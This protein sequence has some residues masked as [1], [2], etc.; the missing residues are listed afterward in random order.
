MLQKRIA[1]FVNNLDEEYQISI[2]KAAREAAK[3][4]GYQLIC[5][6][7]ETIFANKR[8]SF[9]FYSEPWLKVDGILFL[10]SVLGQELGKTEQDYISQ[11][12]KHIPCV[13]I[14]KDLYNFSSILIH[15]KEAFSSLI[16]H[17]VDT[18][19]YRNILYIGGP[20]KHHDNIIREQVLVELTDEYNN[21]DI[22]IV[23]T[24][25]HGAFH[26][27][28]SMVITQKYIQQK[29]SDPFDVIIAANDNMAIGA[30]KAI[31]TSEN[32]NWKK[33]AITG[34]DDIPLASLEYP[35][36]TTI[37]QPL[38]ALGKEAVFLLDSLI[39]H[40][41]PTTRVSARRYVACNLVI[42]ESCG[43][44]TQNQPPVITENIHNY[45]S[46][47]PNILRGNKTSLN[48]TDF[49]TFLYLSIKT[50][51]NMRNLSY[52][53]QRLI[54]VNTHEGMV[55]HLSDFL[56]NLSVSLC[57]LFIFPEPTHNPQEMAHLI[58]KRSNNHDEYY[59]MSSSLQSIREVLHE[60]KEQVLCVY[61]LKTGDKFV[62]I[63]VYNSFDYAQPH[64]CSCATFL[65]NN[66]HRLYE[67]ELEKK[68]TQILE[69][70]VQQ[71]TQELVKA[72]RELQ[73]ESQ[74]REAVELEVLRI[75]EM[76]RLRFSLDLHDDICQRLAGLSM[77]CKSMVSQIPS[78][79]EVIKMID[80][81][82]LL[83]RR[84]A[85]DAFPVELE[86]LGLEKALENLLS[87]MERHTSCAYTFHWDCPFES[88]TLSKAQE[89]NIY[90]IVQEAVNNSIKHGHATQL[91][92]HA[93]FDENKI[94]YISLSDNGHG[95]DLLNQFPANIN[96]GGVGLRSMQYRTHQL[97][98]TLRIQ[99][100]I[101]K[102]TTV[103]IAIPVE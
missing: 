63:L 26:E 68:R 70:Q 44:H 41:D 25:E 36:L 6:Q 2:F 56:S 84:Y 103:S 33:C 78:L 71:R 27:Y 54:T 15:S 50:E 3:T 28:S 80:E 89:I 92:V 30:I 96:V 87:T 75:S 69:E 102:G 7:S 1:L 43:C 14:G 95:N 51:Q 73:E 18:H 22:P 11:L 37:H 47:P 91:T 74:R 35:P 4:L 97:H 40:I 20:E 66:V 85:H 39:H 77:Y 100:S 60:E 5:I 57:F 83:T 90:R 13:S 21:K 42:R 86:N 79:H 65:S 94:F 61:P 49:S 58:Y 93:I 98:G 38:D 82:L 59:P 67:L 99:S 72:Y 53:G 10:S 62:G 19:G 8:Q 9:K 101:E 29:P 34:F 23:L 88:I 16:K 55:K 48:Y 24:I 81:T 12:F 17:L 76:E 45:T 31:E 64:M 52:L 46:L 32:P